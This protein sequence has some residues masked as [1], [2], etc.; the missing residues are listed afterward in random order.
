MILALSHPQPD[1]LLTTRVQSQV[2]SFKPLSLFGIK[3]YGTW[4]FL[5]QHSGGLRL[6]LIQ[7]KYMYSVLK[8]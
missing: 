5:C 6:G 4:T 7:I 1:S 8:A 3:H 2:A